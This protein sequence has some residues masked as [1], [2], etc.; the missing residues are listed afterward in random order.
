M[1]VRRHQSG[2]LIHR[3]ASGNGGRRKGKEY[4][5][6]MQKGKTRRIRM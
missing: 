5:A 6:E 3:R 1:R 2:K 4:L